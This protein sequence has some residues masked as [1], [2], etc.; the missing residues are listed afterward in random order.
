VRALI[1]LLGVA[2]ADVS[3]PRHDA[4]CRALIDGAARKMVE[5][6]YPIFGHSAEMNYGGGAAAYFGDRGLFTASIDVERIPL[7]SLMLTGSDGNWTRTTT[8]DASWA[9]RTRGDW[10]ASLAMSPTTP[11]ELRAFHELFQ[12]VADACLADANRGSSR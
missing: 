12:P 6:G 11:G 2:Y 10:Y 7:W 4:G 9:T 8:Q 5:R 3:V 1:L